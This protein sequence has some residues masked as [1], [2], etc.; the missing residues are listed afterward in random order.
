MRAGQLKERLTLIPPGPLDDNGERTA[1]VSI[2]VACA[3]ENIKI[4]DKVVGNLILA[5]AAAMK[6]I[7]YLP[8]L[9]TSWTAVFDSKSYGITGLEADSRKTWHIVYLKARE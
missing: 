2:E 9:N 8:D 3:S 4:A 5:E 6:R 7:R 1:G